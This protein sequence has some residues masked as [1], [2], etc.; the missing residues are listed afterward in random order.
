MIDNKSVRRTV[1]LPNW[2][3]YAA[4]K[5]KINVSKVLQDALIKEL[6]YAK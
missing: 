4:E 1:T 6:G 5:E 3:D 2:L